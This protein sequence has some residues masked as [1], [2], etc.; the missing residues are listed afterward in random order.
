MPED[1]DYQIEDSPLSQK[2]TRDGVTVEV[3]IYRGEDD[4]G[5]ILEVVDQEGASTIWD[6]MFST[7]KEAL[8]AVLLTI[9]REGITCFLV[10]PKAIR[11]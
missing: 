10:D 7:D 1:D 9:E 6:D 8:D 2:I 5:W 4:P 11:H 3:C